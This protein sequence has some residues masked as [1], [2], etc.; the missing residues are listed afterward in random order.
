MGYESAW[1]FLGRLAPPSF[2]PP[3]FKG[4][5]GNGGT[6]KI[7]RRKKCGKRREKWE[8]KRLRFPG[9][10]EKVG[11]RGKSGKGGKSRADEGVAAEGGLLEVWKGKVVVQ[12][13]AGNF[14]VPGTNFR[15]PRLYMVGPFSFCEM[16][17]FVLRNCGTDL[18]SLTVHK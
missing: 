4:E 6:W 17:G 10:A 16:S 1:W 8:I 2:A 7:S 12:R 9:Q 3:C 13:K 5:V 18:G 11:I 15:W 14:E